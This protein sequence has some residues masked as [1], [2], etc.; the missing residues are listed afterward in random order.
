[1]RLL[2]A[3]YGFGDNHVNEI[4]SDAIGRHGLR[5]FIWDVGADLKGRVLA[6]PH[7]SSVWGG[8]ISTMSRQMIEVFPSDQ[9][10][11]YEYRRL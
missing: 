8:L 4:I 3:G 10:E 5:V 6:A 9:S 7:G 2:I 11:T 1:M